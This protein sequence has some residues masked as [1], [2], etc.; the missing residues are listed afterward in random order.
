MKRTTMAVLALLA[1]GAANLLAAPAAQAVPGLTF[2]SASSA[3]DGADTKSVAVP[4]PAG[5]KPIGGGFFV[6]GG[7][8]GRILVTRLQALESNNTYG[9]TATEADD[10][11]PG[12]WRL[13]GYATC[14][15]APAGLTYVSFSSTSDSSDTKAG[16]A[17][18]PAGRK[19]IGTGA[20]ILGGNGQVVLDDLTPVPSLNSVTVVAYEDS[21][22]Y[23]GNW[24]LWAFAVCADPLANLTLQTADTLPSDSTDDAV[25]VTC[26]GGTKVHG[27]GGAI[28]GGTG[29]VLFGGL[30]PSA[31]LTQSVAVAIEQ[32]GGYGGNWST[33]VYAICAT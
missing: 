21:T 4:C 24:S 1:A 25:G 13:H 27:L 2:A 32:N 15:P 17:A 3:L 10:G 11:A 8:G 18:C 6:S 12:N 23:S 31:D 16:S 20:R 7:A 14:A 19:V 26:P 33:R 9:V 29:A 22:G 28:T 5:T 30:Y